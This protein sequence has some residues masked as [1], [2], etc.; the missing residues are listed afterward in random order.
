MWQIGLI[1]LIGGV[2]AY[3]RLKPPVTLDDASVG[4]R[5]RSPRWGIARTIEWR[6]ERVD[7]L[8][9]LRVESKKVVQIVDYVADYA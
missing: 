8:G 6:L 5:C 7:F 9:K 3:R 1:S 4:Y 2:T